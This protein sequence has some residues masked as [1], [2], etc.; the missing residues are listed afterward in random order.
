MLGLM[1]PGIVEIISFLLGLSGLGFQPNPKAPTVDAV[2]QYAMPDADIVVHFDIGSVVP[3]NYKIISHLAEDPRIKASPEIAKVI[4]EGV[5]QLEGGRGLVKQMTGLDVTTDINDATLFVRFAS[6]HEPIMLSEVHG[7]FTPVLLEKI[8]KMQGGKTVKVGN[9]TELDAGGQTLAIT[10][11]G[12]LLAGSTALVNERLAAAWKAP[13]HAA[14]TTLGATADLIA[15]KPVFGMVVALAAPARTAAIDA[16]GR[17]N[18]VGDLLSRHKLA[19]LGIFHDGI[20]WTWTDSTKAGYDSMA[21]ISEGTLELFRAGQLAPRAIGKIVIGGLESYRADP[22]VAQLLDHKDD[23][24]KLVSAFTGDGSFKQ[25]I[26]RDPKTLTLHV[27]ATG[28]S[29]SEV[30]PLAALAPL[31]GLGYFVKSSHTSAP[32]EMAKPAPLSPS[33]R[34]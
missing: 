25:Q 3:G 9:A 8:A 7:N 15:G 6:A 28:K 26:D 30:V 29:F 23:L 19:A 34:P 11:G 20:G 27:R 18:F 33:M 12:V 21:T 4:S 16:V 14:G 5:A 2:M 10:Q 22:R 17:T 31:A 24:M 1:S 32:M 13:T